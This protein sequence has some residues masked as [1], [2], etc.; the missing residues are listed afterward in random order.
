[1]RFSASTPPPRNPFKTLL[2]FKIWGEKKPRTQ[3]AKKSQPPHKPSEIRIKS[4]T[5]WAAS[6][7]IAAG[8][9]RPAESP[10][11]IPSGRPSPLHPGPGGDA[12][13]AEGGLALRGGRRGGGRGADVPPRTAL[14]SRPGCAQLG[15][16]G[17]GRREEG[18]EPR[19]AGRGLPGAPRAGPAPAE[20]GPPRGRG[21]GGRW[22]RQHG[23]AG[24]LPRAGPVT[25]PRG[26]PRPRPVTP[27]L[28]PVGWRPRRGAGVPP[29]RVQP[30]ASAGPGAS[31]PAAEPSVPGSPARL[32]WEPRCVS[33]T[34]REPAGHRLPT[35]HPWRC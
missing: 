7:L 30:A 35:Q 15:E 19:A 20:G 31:C 24:S 18:P 22:Q 5:G 10:T 9:A 12:P 28:R 33:R 13:G 32:L 3:K 1:M 16:G 21:S 2:S 8:K 17:D 26:D 34:Q 11:R 6:P 29:L 4:S 25:R 27:P 14:P 23:R